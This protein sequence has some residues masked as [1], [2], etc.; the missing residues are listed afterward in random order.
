MLNIILN[1]ILIPTYKAYGAAIASLITQGLT[2][3]AQIWLCKSYFKLSFNNSLITRVVLFTTITLALGLAL[4]QSYFSFIPWHLS[5]LILFFS[6]IVLL[7]AL[8]IIEIKNVKK[9]F[10]K[11]S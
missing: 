2:S 9:L 7:F 11:S 3:I 8:Q 10:Q 1:L 4:N 6:G 5:L